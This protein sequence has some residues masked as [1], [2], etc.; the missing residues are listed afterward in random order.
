VLRRNK[1]LT[2]FKAED[3][4]VKVRKRGGRKREILTK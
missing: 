2:A 3:S 4:S 1:A